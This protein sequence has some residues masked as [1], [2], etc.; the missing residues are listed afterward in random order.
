MAVISVKFVFGHEVYFH[1]NPM[2]ILTSFQKPDSTGRIQR[3]QRVLSQSLGTSRYT[4]CAINQGF[5]EQ[6]VL[7]MLKTT[8][9]IHVE[10]SVV[11]EKLMLDRSAI[12]REDTY[13]ITIEIRHNVY[14]QGSSKVNGADRSN[15]GPRNRTEGAIDL[16]KSQEAM[17]SERVEIIKAKYL[18][19]CDG[20]HSWTRRQ[21]GLPLEGEQ[22]DHIWGVIDIVPLTN[23]RAF[24][25]FLLLE[26]EKRADMLIFL[27]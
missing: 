21:V 19:G 11:P 12:E 4:Q 23:F 9:K 15:G 1:L 10:R 14:D 22:S 27:S 24:F 8:G 26:I 6:T 5:I 25:F 7:D 13:P 17:K 3:E 2:Q 18:L 16:T 20:G